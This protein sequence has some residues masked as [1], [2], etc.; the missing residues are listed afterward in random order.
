MLKTTDEHTGGLPARPPFKLAKGP[1]VR[2]RTDQP[3]S[4]PADEDAA[5]RE[6]IAEW[7][8]PSLA[9]PGVDAA[10]RAPG[11]NRRPHATPK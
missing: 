5:L 8:A 4:S 11:P 2:R 6:R 7:A 10:T 3:V 1:T 9:A